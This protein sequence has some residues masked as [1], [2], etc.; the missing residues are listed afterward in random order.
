[1]ERREGLPW[2]RVPVIILLSELLCFDVFLVRKAFPMLA[3]MGG[4]NN[5]DESFPS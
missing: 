5:M 2:P 4:D 3:R 1:M